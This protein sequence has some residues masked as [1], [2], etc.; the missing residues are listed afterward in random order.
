MALQNSQ[1][2]GEILFLC[3]PPGSI[4]ENEPMPIRIAAAGVA[5]IQHI[6]ELGERADATGQNGH[7]VVDVDLGG[8]ILVVAAGIGNENLEPT[9]DD[10][11]CPDFGEDMAYEG[12]CVGHAG[13]K[14]D[15][16]GADC[17]QTCNRCRN[18]EGVHL[19]PV[20]S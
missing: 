16:F 2:P 19:R 5:A 9:K 7:E 6:V 10:T 20:K 4:P 18:R 13:K 3:R 1:D 14:A 15:D 8:M 17:K 11:H 12:R